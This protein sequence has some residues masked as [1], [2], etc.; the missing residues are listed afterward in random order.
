ML[1]NT[2]V[3]KYIFL[4]ENFIFIDFFSLNV[5]GSDTTPGIWKEIFIK[6]IQTDPWDDV[7]SVKFNCRKDCGDEIFSWQDILQFFSGKSNF[8]IFKL[9]LYI[10]IYI[11]IYYK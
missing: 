1:T 3:Y 4:A 6:F 10:Y 9:Y 7:T 11:Y 8:T 2:E 5:H